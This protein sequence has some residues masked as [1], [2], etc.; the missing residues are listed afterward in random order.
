M[1][2][3]V[4]ELELII[5]DLAFGGLDTA[6]GELLMRL[7]T[8]AALCRELG[9]SMGEELCG[10]LKESIGGEGSVDALCRLSF[11]CEALKNM[12]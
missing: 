6:G 7:D 4:S 5:S 9:M 2:R 12:K 1:E 10:S 8:A 11:F 3:L